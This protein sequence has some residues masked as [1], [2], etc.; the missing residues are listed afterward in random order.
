MMEVEWGRVLPQSELFDIDGDLFQ[1]H[2]VLG[3]VVATIG[4]AGNLHDIVEGLQP[5]HQKRCDGCRAKV[6]QF[7]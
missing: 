3:A 6:L 2:I 4:N 5:L 7:Q 1:D